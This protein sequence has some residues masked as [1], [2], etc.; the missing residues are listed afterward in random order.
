MPVPIVMDRTAR[1]RARRELELAW[2]KSPLATALFVCKRYKTNNAK[3][4][5]VLAGNKDVTNF[6]AKQ[7]PGMQQL[8]LVG[9]QTFFSQAR[10]FAQLKC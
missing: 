7:D 2:W 1:K 8:E 5:F 9:S 4:L 6:L 10:S 3:Y